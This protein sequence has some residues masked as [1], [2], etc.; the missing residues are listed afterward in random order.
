MTVYNYV[1]LKRE[2]F[3]CTYINYIYVYQVKESVSILVY[4]KDN[5]FLVFFLRDSLW[6]TSCINKFLTLKYCVNK[7]CLRKQFLKFGQVFID[8]EYKTNG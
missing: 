8:I 7:Q 5:K 3:E 6:I 4:S 2:N 1:V